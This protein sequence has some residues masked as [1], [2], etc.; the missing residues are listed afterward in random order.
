MDTL[1]IILDVV[2]LACDIGI[3]VMLLN[4]FKK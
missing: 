3:L 1:R 2:I 4:L